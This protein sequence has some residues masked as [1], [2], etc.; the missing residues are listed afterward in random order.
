MKNI[1]KVSGNFALLGDEVQLTIPEGQEA[2]LRLYQKTSEVAIFV[3]V[4]NATP[5]VNSIRRFRAA[6]QNAALPDNFVKY[7]GVMGL[8]EVP[9]GPLVETHIIELVPVV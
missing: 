7:I 6:D 1:M 3:V 9:N 5:T 4:D 8:P 2:A